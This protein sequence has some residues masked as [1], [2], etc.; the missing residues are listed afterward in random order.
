MIYKPLL[1]PAILAVVGFEVEVQIRAAQ[2]DGND[3]NA[4]LAVMASGGSKQQQSSQG[5]HNRD[6]NAI[7]KT[8]PDAAS[9][10]LASKR[11]DR[12][13]TLMSKIN[14]RTK[15]SMPISNNP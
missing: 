12:R 11:E 15:E 6:H 14:T 13:D 8:R 4:Y 2:G 10:D 5:Q 3:T 7:P 1:V 9:K